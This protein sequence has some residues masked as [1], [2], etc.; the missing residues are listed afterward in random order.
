MTDR[1]VEAIDALCDAV[2]RYQRLGDRLNEGDT[3]RS[4]ST[5]HWCPGRGSEA[6]ATGLEAIRL[7]EA[8]P[9]S[10]ELAHAYLNLAFLH[11]VVRE[12]RR[13]HA[14]EHASLRRRRPAR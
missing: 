14:V 7:L 1:G 12:T 5:I 2:G 6:P 10:R 8:L 11:L 4:L 13:R 3:L 9:P